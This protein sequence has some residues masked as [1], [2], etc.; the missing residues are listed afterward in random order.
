MTTN[1]G[2]AR[3][4]SGLV[5][6]GAGVLFLAL[7]VAWLVLIA[8]YWT[9]IIMAILVPAAV[10]VRIAGMSKVTREAPVAA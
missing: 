1:R 4:I 8:A 6:F 5:L 9:T 3:G 2:A 10:A 7:V